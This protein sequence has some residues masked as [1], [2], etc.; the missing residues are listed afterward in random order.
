M[1]KYWYT[2][3]LAFS[4]LISAIISTLPASVY[5]IVT[6]KQAK[7]KIHIRRSRL[8]MILLM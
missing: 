7:L 8:F 3:L 6:R 5:G 2:L 1:K 4:L